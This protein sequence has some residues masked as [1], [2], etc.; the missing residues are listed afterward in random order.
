MFELILT[1]YVQVYSKHLLL[2][3]RFSIYL[4]YNLYQFLN[5]YF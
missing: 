3:Y 5:H 2:Q 1:Y 4:D